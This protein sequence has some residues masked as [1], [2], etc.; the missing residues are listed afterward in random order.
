MDGYI[1]SALCIGLTL[2]AAGG[3]CQLFVSRRP[4]VF[5]SVVTLR[6]GAI[7]G[8]GAAVH[9]YKGIPFAAPPVG[10]MRWRAPA[11]PLP[12]WGVRSGADFGADC[13]QKPDARLRAKSMSEDCLYANVWTPAQHPNENLPVMVF[14]YGGSFDHGSGSRFDYDGEQLAA[15]GVVVVNFNYRMGV[16]GFFAHKELAAESGNKSSGNYA[17]LDQIA[18]LH[19]VKQNI[20]AFG[21]DPARVTIFGQS[22]GGSSVNLLLISP[23]AKGLFRNAIS[24]SPGPLWR[25]AP[26][27]AAE[28]GWEQ[29]GTDIGALRSL[30]AEELLTKFD[31]VRQVPLPP[32]AARI[33]GPI[34]DG[35]IIPRSEREAYRTR[36]VTIVPLI[37]GNVANESGLSISKTPIQTIDLYREYMRRRFGK[38]ADQ[39]MAAYPV[40]KDSDVPMAVVAVSTDNQHGFE[41]RSIAEAMVRINPKV[42]RYYFSRHRG[43]SLNPPVHAEDICYIFGHLNAPTVQGDPSGG[44]GLVVTQPFNRIDEQLSETIMTMFAR[45][46][47]TSDPNGPALP[48]WPKYSNGM[49]V[50]FGS[51]VSAVKDTHKDQLDAIQE[52]FDDGAKQ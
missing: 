49:Y 20:H 15:K 26:L 12:W 23:L 27:V 5:P 9:S 46:A 22:A 4:A 35:W 38:N 51:T 45:F 50:E 43:D 8:S 10:T 2:L 39:I 30:S 28:K 6:S 1:R 42:Y 24:E 36:K 47:A 32:G 11:S 44:N 21:G 34:I 41:A 7:S 31:A 18:A 33:G 29:F 37:I 3:R 48:I 40:A 25:L 13:E 19:W 14:I 17:L 52:Y 16:F